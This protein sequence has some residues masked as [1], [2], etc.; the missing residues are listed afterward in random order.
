MNG[1]NLVSADLYL[2]AGKQAW[3]DGQLTNKG[4]SYWKVSIHTVQTVPTAGCVA[5][6]LN[7]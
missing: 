2:T 6:L 3:K 4:H 5:F 1:V 7:I